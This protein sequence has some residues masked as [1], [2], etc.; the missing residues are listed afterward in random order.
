[1]KKDFFFTKWKT[2]VILR[3]VCERGFVIFIYKG[4]SSPC[5]RSQ[6]N[7]RAAKASLPTRVAFL[8][9]NLVNSFSLASA[10]TVLSQDSKRSISLTFCRYLVKKQT[11]RS[12]FVFY[13]RH[14]KNV[15]P[16]F[17]SFFPN[18]IEIFSPIFLDT[19][20]SLKKTNYFHHNPTRKAKE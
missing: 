18:K 7:E 4:C 15:N 9:A 8:S 20:Y 16:F 14:D 6:A 1:V 11:S 17:S 13:R 12:T 2:D 10:E 3:K 19:L 5:I